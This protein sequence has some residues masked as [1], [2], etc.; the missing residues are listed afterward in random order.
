MLTL[1]HPWKR[2]SKRALHAAL[3]SFSKVS[4]K[5]K[6]K[7][8]PRRPALLSI[9]VTA[10]L[11][12]D[13]IFVRETLRVTQ[14][15]GFSRLASLFAI[16][17]FPMFTPRDPRGCDQS[18]PSPIIENQSSSTRAKIRQAETVNARGQNSSGIYRIY[19]FFLFH[20]VHPLYDHLDEAVE[21]RV[22]SRS[23]RFILFFSELENATSACSLQIAPSFLVFL[24][25]FCAHEGS[26]RGILLFNLSIIILF[27]SKK[28]G[29]SFS[30][31]PFFI[32]V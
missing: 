12:S 21:K 25:L 7:L 10:K 3:H 26:L 17:N 2:K 20:S 19:P 30:S 13:I 29:I 1:K 22:V 23:F 15:D 24:F 5:P 11:F 27:F 28:R 32:F 31:P 16:F 8:S 4:R 9:S 6:M 14:I 18:F